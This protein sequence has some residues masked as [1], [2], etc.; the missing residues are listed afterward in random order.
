MKSTNSAFT[1]I[2]LLVVITILVM[3]LALLMPALDQAVYQAELAVCG[4]RLDAVATGAQTYALNFKRAY[5]HRRAALWPQILS[6][7]SAGNIDDRLVMR[8]YIPINAALRC[9]LSGKV[10]LAREDVDEAGRIVAAYSSY[11]IWFG[12][13][14][15]ISGVKTSPL[16]KLGDRWTYT[17]GQELITSD[18]LAMDTDMPSEVYR[19]AINSHPDSDGVLY[20]WVMDNAPY[21]EAAGFLPTAGTRFA[22]AYLWE[23]GG[24]DRGAVDNNYVHTDGS[25][26]RITGVEFID[27]EMVRLRRNSNG[28]TEWTVQVPTR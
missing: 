15:A 21:E 14:Y 28:S 6:I 12:F 1:L 23:T 7:W 19:Q 26:T 11:N 22:L 18:L 13:T 24:L 8:D 20:P 17:L 4:A 3:L 27:R 25:V 16:K 10:D 5:P 9:P 2:E